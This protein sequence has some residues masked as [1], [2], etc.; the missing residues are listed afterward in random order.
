M[1]NVQIFNDATTSYHMFV[2]KWEIVSEDDF[3]TAQKR[4]RD[5]FNHDDPGARLMRYLG[6]HHYLKVPGGYQVPQGAAAK[7]KA[8]Q[9]PHAAVLIKAWYA[10]HSQE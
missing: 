5:L 9:G 10:K 1:S 3:H 4:W 2:L 6:T 7:L 8:L